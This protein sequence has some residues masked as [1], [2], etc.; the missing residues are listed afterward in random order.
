MPLLDRP[1]TLRLQDPPTRNAHDE[2]VP[3]A[4]R[5]VRVWAQ[6][7]EAGSYDDYLEGGSTVVIQLRNFV[8]RW[9][10][11][12]AATLVGRVQVRDENGVTWRGQN[13]APSD[14]RRKYFTI[15]AISPPTSDPA[16][17]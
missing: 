13:V 14:R 2:T 5:E 16:S 10:A 11:D 17:A 9:R 4:W 12:L 8:V 6:V 15:S 3:G 7:Q 1:V